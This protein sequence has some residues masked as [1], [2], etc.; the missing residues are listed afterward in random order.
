VQIE[1]M[2]NRNPLLPRGF[3]GAISLDPQT[4]HMLGAR[5]AG[6]SGQVIGS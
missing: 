4:R 6:A 5:T 2:A 1:E 3:W